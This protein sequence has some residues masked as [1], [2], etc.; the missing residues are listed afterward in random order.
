MNALV[1]GVDSGTR[2]GQLCRGVINR[3]SSPIIFGAVRIFRGGVIGLFAVMSEVACEDSSQLRSLEAIVAKF[4]SLS[5]S[6][7]GRN[8]RGNFG[9]S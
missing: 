6:D 7:D 9:R 2:R 5:F 1:F 4:C 8:S 3:A